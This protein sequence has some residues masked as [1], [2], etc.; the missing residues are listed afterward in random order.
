MLLSSDQPEEPL[1]SVRLNFCLITLVQ[2]CTL[3]LKE[4]IE[5]TSDQ[6]DQGLQKDFPEGSNLWTMNAV[7]ERY[8]T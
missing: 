1:S 4:M 7:N 6:E 2:V 3:V 8:A 5:R